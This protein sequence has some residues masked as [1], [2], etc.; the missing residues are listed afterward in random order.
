MRLSRWPIK[1]DEAVIYFNREIILP[2]GGSGLWAWQ[3]SLY[4]WM[5]QNAR[6]TRDYYQVQ[7]TQIIEIGLPVL[8]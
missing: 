7:P 4:A 6:P 8:L 5:S 3:R 2:G 1:P